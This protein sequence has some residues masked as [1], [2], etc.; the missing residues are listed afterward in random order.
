MSGAI[1]ALAILLSSSAMGAEVVVGPGGADTPDCNATDSPRSPNS[2]PC[3][4][5]EVSR[6]SKSKIGP[7]PNQAPAKKGSPESFDAI[8][9]AQPS[10]SKIFTIPSNGTRAQPWNGTTPKTDALQKENVAPLPILQRDFPAKP[11]TSNRPPTESVTSATVTSTSPER[12]PIT[13]ATKTTSTTSPKPTSASYEASQLVIYWKDSN[14]AASGLAVMAREFRLL[15]ATENQL[16]HLG[17]T[18][19]TFKLASQSEAERIRNLLTVRY[20]T[21]RI[22]FHARY[23]PHQSQLSVPSENQTRAVPAKLRQFLFSSIDYKKPQQSAGR[24]VRVGIVDTSVDADGLLK[25]TSILQR[26]FLTFGEIPASPAHGSALAALIAGVDDANDFSGVSPGSALYVAAIMRLQGAD[27]ASNTATLVRALDWLLGERVQVINLS[28][29]GPGDRVMEEAISRLIRSRVIV[30]SAAGNQGENAAPSYPAAYPGVIAVTAC[31]ARN[32]IF[33]QS[34]RGPYISLTAPGVDIWT[35]DRRGGRYVSG[36]SYAAAVVSGAAAILLARQ[37]GLDGNT[38]RDLM[39]KHARDIGNPGMDSV[40]GC[41]LLQIQ[42]TLA[43][44]SESGSE[45]LAKESVIR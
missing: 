27:T 17:G 30:V 24:G 12:L 4:G 36:T 41:G 1:V 28:L 21:W 20:P 33:E 5:R 44:I 11:I 19:V 2:G 40:Y 32:Q 22:D 26:T 9:P 15:P 29:G 23:L 8:S 16:P 31:D 35:P 39:C 7:S 43:A 13:P 3:K 18:I 14:E 42:A 25:H 37:P 6:S 45:T 34:N 38:A 10:D